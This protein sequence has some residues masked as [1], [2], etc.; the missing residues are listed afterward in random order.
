MDTQNDALEKLAP[1]KDGSIFGL[2]NFWGA[3]KR[4]F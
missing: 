3:K 4:H 1:F 2:L